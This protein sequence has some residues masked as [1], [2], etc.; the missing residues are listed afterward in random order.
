MTRMIFEEEEDI[1]DDGQPI[2]PV[3]D[4]PDAEAVAADDAHPLTGRLFRPACICERR[5][6]EGEPGQERGRCDNRISEPWKKLRQAK[7]IAAP[8]GVELEVN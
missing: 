7:Q 2:A 8:E 1:L 5:K 6:R 3:T 4:L